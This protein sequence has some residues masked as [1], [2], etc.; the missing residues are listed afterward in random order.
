MIRLLFF[1][2]T[3]VCLAMSTSIAQ[4]TLVSTS[5]T[6]TL[7]DQV[8]FNAHI[9]PIMS[10]TCFTC[11]GPDAEDNESEFRMDSFEYATG[12]LPSDDDRRGIVPG[13]VSQSEVIARI[14]GTSD[15]EQMPP[16]RFRH[17]LTS[18]EKALF[19]KWV[20]Q[21]AAYEQHWAYSP[22]TKPDLPTLSRFSDRVGNEIDA[23]ILSQLEVAGLEP[24]PPADRAKLLRRLS[25]DLTGLPPTPDQVLAF[26]EDPSPNAYETQVDRLLQSPHY[27]ERMA[28]FWLDLI[29]FADTV[30][31]HGDQNLRN[32][33]YRDYVIDSFNHNLP[34]DEFTR[35]QIAGDLKPQP[36]ID[37]LTATAV[38]RLNMVTREGGA[39]PGEYLAKYKA[40]RV[41]MLGTAWLGSTLGCCECHNHKYDPFSI[42]DFYSLGA[43]F[44]DVRQWGVYSD[45]GYTPN[46]DLRGFSND[47]PFPPEMRVESESLKRQIRSLQRERDTHL[48][49]AL[50]AQ[51]LDHPDYKKWSDSIN[52]ILVV[53]PDGWIPANIAGVTTSEGTKHEINPD[54]SVVFLG[55]AKTG[56]TLTLDV[57][58][59]IESKINSIRLECLPDE[60]H[61]GFVGRGSDGRFSLGFTASIVREVDGKWERR[62]NMT[63]YL[64]VETQDAQPLSLAEMQVFAVGDDGKTTNVALQGTAKQSSQYMDAEASRAIDGDTNG[65][66]GG[67][68]ITHT[69]V[70]DNAPW[71]EL[72]LGK[73]YAVAK[74]SIWGRT[75]GQWG[76][77]LDGFKV[78]LLDKERR[79]V[80]WVRPPTPK[81][82]IHLNVPLDVP[83]FVSQPIAWGEADREVPSNYVNGAPPRFLGEIWQSGPA[84]WTLPDNENTLPHTAIFHFKKPFTLGKDERL[85]I[86]FTSGNVGRV[87]VSFTPIGN[88]IAGWPAVSSELAKSLAKTPTQ[89]DSVDRAALVCAFHCSTTPED[90]LHAIARTYRDRIADLHSGIATTL[91]VQSLPKDQIPPSKVRP[92]G[93]W[94][95]ESGESAPPATPHFLPMQESDSQRRLTRMDLAD[96]L[97]SPTNPLV[98]RHFVNR[99]WKQFFGT[100]LSGKL[101]DLGS[102]GEWPSHP[103]LLDRLATEFVES[104]WNVKGLVKKMVMSRTYQQAVTSRM[105]LAESDPYNRLLA[106]AS[107]RRLEAEV[108]R[109]N[110]LSIAG[111]LQTEVIGGP[112]AFPYQPSG[113]YSNLQ[114]PDR[115]YVDSGDSRQYRRGVYMHWQRTFLHPMLVNFDAPSRDECTADRSQS[116]S[117]QQALTLLNDSTFAE[118]SH[119]M[120]QRVLLA[121]EG[122]DF[123]TILDAAF[124]LALARIAKPREQ[125]ALR[126]L[127]ERQSEYF[128]SNPEEANKFVRVGNSDS[129]KLDSVNVAAW[130]QVMRVILN[131]HETITRY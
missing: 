26:V 110:A 125:E 99:T 18:Y 84:R 102:Q 33:L 72:D 108:I 119:A 56:E 22:L 6:Q 122:A 15:G 88:A 23:F 100:G 114:F 46:P 63:R 20:Q 13:D 21:G 59:S 66:Y 79:E 51:S 90:S 96:W 89:R 94:Q 131:L 53:H 112:S 4:E 55:E 109:D 76:E 130:S 121:N 118:A 54:G 57:S 65:D 120:A 128:Q 12:Q 103:L 36:T 52:Q 92:R 50:S 34:F 16:G 77:R 35:Q 126:S 93:N 111:L 9:R 64:R 117:P 74:L 82:S 97:T 32:F 42:K 27:G 5:K 40:D 86:Q 116:N 25:L 58:P 28:G 47:Y 30:G 48:L 11:H 106:Q 61:G 95:D 87:R 124:E 78:K 127:Y 129:D 123:E 113:Y 41:R 104:D 2:V 83:K 43:F 75:D 31:F 85:V 115:E 98:S 37:D 101:D 39:Q 45:Y 73:E 67:R 14:M 91:V 70:D 69:G 60:H 80:H 49:A 8:T 38:L 81:P 19:A 1:F 3:A 71:W 62:K 17:Q 107:P 29:R 24:S 7:P 105:D 10:N 68:S 44:D